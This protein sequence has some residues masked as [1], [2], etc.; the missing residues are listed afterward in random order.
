MV[1]SGLVGGLCKGADKGPVRS[2]PSTPWLPD[3]L[4]PLLITLSTAP[5]LRAGEASPCVHTLLHVPCYT[6]LQ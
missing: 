5:A 2:L 3:L 1:L 4:F 6:F